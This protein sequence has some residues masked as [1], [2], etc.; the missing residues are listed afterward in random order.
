VGIYKSWLSELAS[1]PTLI[2]LSQTYIANRC[3]KGQRKVTEMY[4]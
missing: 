2:Q 1:Y 4:S 3:V